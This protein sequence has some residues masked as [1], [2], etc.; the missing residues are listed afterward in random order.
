MQL[1]PLLHPAMDC[2]FALGGAAATQTQ[3]VVSEFGHFRRLFC[4]FKCLETIRPITF[5]ETTYK[6]ES[7][8]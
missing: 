7:A 5:A 1:K 2:I 6:Q 8:G 4:R 3:Q